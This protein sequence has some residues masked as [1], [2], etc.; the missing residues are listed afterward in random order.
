MCGIFFSCSRQT[1]ILPCKIICEYLNRRGPDS[2]NTIHREFDE[3]S[4]HIAPHFPNSKISLTFAAS[5]LSLRGNSLT[6]QPLE[7]LQTGSIFCWNGEAWKIKDGVCEGNDAKLVFD[8]LLEAIKSNATSS[9]VD[10]AVMSAF[11]NVSG[12]SAFVFYD[13]LRHKIFYGR[14]RLGR[15]S[16]LQSVDSDGALIISSICHPAQFETWTEVKSGW[17]YILD[18][19]E[20]ARRGPL[21]AVV[22]R[23][24]QSL[25][26]QSQNSASDEFGNIWPEGLHSV[27][28]T[29][30]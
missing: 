5:V 14:D 15:R 16:L 12:P 2:F 30:Q 17:M 18:L 22:S 7:D 26:N 29:P 24:G 27:V 13:G 8:V 23:N 25:N 19:A 9:S 10:D 11:H 6:E 3:E 20:Y 4:L 1:P 21:Q 28:H